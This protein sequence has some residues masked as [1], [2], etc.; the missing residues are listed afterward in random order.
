MGLPRTLVHY[1]PG[2]P[3]LIIRKARGCVTFHMY[4]DQD[5]L[6]HW[7]LNNGDDERV[8]NSSEGYESKRECLLAVLLIK[9]CHTA[10]V[11]GG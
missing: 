1:G 8:A 11:E 9:Q 6:W 3:P 5:G 4:Q 2:Q 7:Y 10:P